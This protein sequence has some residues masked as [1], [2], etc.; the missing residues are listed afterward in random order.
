[1]FL[2]S[3]TCVA[4][5][6]LLQ[7][8]AAVQTWNQEPSRT[9]V[10]P[11]GNA[12]LACKI[13]NKQGT[14]SWQKDGKP[15]GMFVGKYEWSGDM[16][17]GDCSIR[18]SDASEVDDGDWE[19]Q[20]TASAFTA[21][22]ALT[23]RIAQLVVRVAP[24]RPQMEVDTLQVAAGQNFTVTEGRPGSIKC[25][26]R[27]GNPPAEIKWFIGDRELPAEEYDQTNATEVDK[28]KTWMG[29]SVL[30]HTYV[31]EDHGQP[32]RCVAVHQAYQTK[33]EFVEVIMDVQYT[34][35]VTLEGAPND[36]VEE[37]IDNVTLRCLV[38]AN[39]AAN[40]VW[41]LLGANDVFSFQK[42]VSFRPVQR[43]HS[44]TYT[45]EARNPVGASDP[46]SVKIDVKY[47]PRVLQVGPA[48]IVTATLHNHTLLECLAEG[49]PPPKYTWIQTIPDSGKTV[50]RG[51][52][53]TL[54]LE[55]M[56]YE[57]QGQYV[58]VASNTI[59]GELIEDTSTPVTVE[60]VGA[61]HVLRYTVNRNVQVAKGE[62][63]VIQVVFCSDPQPSRTTW[64]WGSLRLEAGN[65]QG[66]YVAENLAQDSR[67]DCYAARLRVQ[68]ADA[69][70]ARDYHL[71]VENDKGADQYTVSLLVNGLVDKPPLQ[72]VPPSAEPV[73]MSTVIGIVIACLV[74]LVLVTL[75]VLY[76][77]KTEKWCF[78][79]RGDFK[80]TDLESDKSDL[81][82]QKGNNGRHQYSSSGS[83]VG[84]SGGKTLVEGSLASIPPDAFYTSASK[85]TSV[86]TLSSKPDHE[87][88]NLK[89]MPTPTA[90]PS[91]CQATRR[92]SSSSS[93]NSSQTTRRD[94]QIH[95]KSDTKGEAATTNLEEQTDMDGL[96]LRQGEMQTFKKQDDHHH[97]HHHQQD[98]A[99]DTSKTMK[100][101]PILTTSTP[102]Y[103]PVYQQHEKS[104][105]A[106]TSGADPRPGGGILYA[107]LQ[108]PRS[109][110]NGSM[111]R[112]GNRHAQQK[113]QYAEITFQGRPLQTA[114]I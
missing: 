40:I 3:F 44:A 60:V 111:R 46:I 18:I 101:A 95:E 34:P 76:A 22:D 21:Q 73:S 96:N 45:C 26:S 104:K 68:G 1:M 33:S 12:V 109:S 6:A 17:A 10:N 106:K 20:V 27:Y 83:G 62:D 74:V 29:V 30:T 110:N 72:R 58:C 55:S 52:N 61:P 50:V 9:E 91:S 48:P 14:C 89:I 79:Q 23:S 112:G 51:N 15:Q 41:K 114:E 37:G 90:T 66:R 97:P 80:P 53:A 65:G 99:K 78:S 63:A 103:V 77:F 13:Y 43:K 16:E 54:L 25:V 59:K 94:E 85:H 81:E 86:S 47:A 31:K 42:E 87:Y 108:L 69:A 64:E 105:S 84:R 36:D 102:P 70:D 82:S 5:A 67:E 75:L 4:L 8:T 71:N 19:C 24:S 11:G 107:E 39:P 88:E 38:D 56:T 93:S 28:P 113:T 2:S 92:N 7:G 100:T 32:L 98:E 57:H 35:T 49:N